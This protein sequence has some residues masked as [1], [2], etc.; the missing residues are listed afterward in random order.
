MTPVNGSDPRALLEAIQTS[1]AQVLVSLEDV[2]VA[3]VLSPSQVNMYLGCPARW[4]YKYISRLPD[5]RGGSLVRGSAVHRIAETYYRL[6]ARNA[7]P[8]DTA[9]FVSDIL[10]QVWE[11]QCLDAAFASDEKPGELKSQAGVLSIMY[12]DEIAT[13]IEPARIE[14][15]MVGVIGGVDVQGWIDL[16][17]TAGTVHDT[18]TATRKPFGV[19]PGYAFQAATYAQLVPDCGG[20]VQLTTLVA[21]KKPQVVV[22]A[23]EVSDAD[24][25]LTETMYPA[26]QE[27]MR[28]G[29]VLPNRESNLCGQKYCPFWQQCEKDWGGKVKGGAEA[30]A[31]V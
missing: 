8:A 26:V 18:K 4:G 16:Q 29:R 12:L 28:Q 9:G 6:K 27:S 13:K 20:L 19:S 5:V 15:R 10:D 17:D 14:E 1:A 22:M 23:Y 3:D 30:E 11:E 31:G 21:T 24:I 25:R 7:A 2:P